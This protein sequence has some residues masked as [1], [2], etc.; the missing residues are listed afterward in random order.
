[1][2]KTSHGFKNIASFTA[3]KV[4]ARLKE[5]AQREEIRLQFESMYREY[6]I[7]EETEKNDES[8]KELEPGVTKDSKASEW[9]QHSLDKLR[10][11]VPNRLIGSDGSVVEVHQYFSSR[12]NRRKKISE[13]TSNWRPSGNSAL[14]GYSWV[15]TAP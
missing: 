15:Q 4:Q 9:A 1:M 5:E 12:T 11:V 7:E 3:T 14:L 2:V 10:T 6:G 13:T 8:E